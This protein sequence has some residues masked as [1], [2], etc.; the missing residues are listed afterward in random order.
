[1]EAKNIVPD[2]A[3]EAESYEDSSRTEYRLPTEIWM[4]IFDIL[5]FVPGWMDADSPDPFAAGQKDPWREDPIPDLRWACAAVRVCQV[6]RAVATPFLYR[7]VVIRNGRSI[8]CLHRTLLEG[9]TCNNIALRSYIHRLDLRGGLRHTREIFFAAI[10]KLVRETLQILSFAE[11]PAF[12]D[13]SAYLHPTTGKRASRPK[14]WQSLRVLKI[15]SSPRRPLYAP[16]MHFLTSTPRLRHLHIGPLLESHIT[17]AGDTPPPQPEA[18]ILPELLSLRL[19]TPHSIDFPMLDHTHLPSLHKLE[20]DINLPS[21]SLP[22]PLR[23]TEHGLGRTLTTIVAHI[24]FTLTPEFTEMLCE[25]CPLLTRLAIFL[26]SWSG[27]QASLHLPR[28]THLAIGASKPSGDRCLW[29][30]QILPTIVAPALQVVRLISVGRR[31]IGDYHRAEPTV[32]DYLDFRTDLRDNIRSCSF[33]F[34]D[35][36]GSLV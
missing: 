20:V 22:V 6:W 23:S 9:S 26:R 33:R 25:S 16:L 7:Y 32:R 21:P 8:T 1:M 29:L 28:I 17:V 36:Y 15:L 12:C 13:Y 10:L 27:L 2:A 5:T 14:P 11:Y 18:V 31:W 3:V 4:Q 30:L 19:P 35:D 34:E 24:N